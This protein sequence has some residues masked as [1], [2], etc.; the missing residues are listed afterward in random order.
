MVECPLYNFIRHR[1]PSLLKNVV[2]GSVKSFFS[3]YH[4][5]GISLYLTKATILH[6]DRGMG[7]FDTILMVDS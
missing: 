3:L 5:V 1:F 6:Y 4:Q 2:L 7:I